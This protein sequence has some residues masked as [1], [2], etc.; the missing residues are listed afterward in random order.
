MNIKIKSAGVT[1]LI[2]DDYDRVYTA[3]KNKLGGDDEQLFTERIPGHEYLQWELPGEGWTPLSEGDPLMVQEVRQEL[4]K[5]KQVISQRFGANQ[6]MAQRILSVPDDSYVYYKANAEGRLLIRLTAWG[7]RYPERIGGGGAEGERKPKGNT[8]FVCI[9]ILYDNKPLPNKEFFVNGFK[10]VTDGTG[11]Y[12][13]GDLPIGYK[14]ELKVGDKQQIVEVQ[15]GQSDIQVDTTLFASVEIRAM[16]DGNPYSEVTATLS[17]WGHE[18]KL[19][20]D[21]NGKAFAKVPQDPDNGMCTIS[22]GNDYQQLPL[23]QPLTVFSFNVVSPPKE[24]EHPEDDTPGDTTGDVGKEEQNPGDPEIKE[25]KGDGGNQDT[26]QTNDDNHEVEAVDD[27]RDEEE[28]KSSG[29]DETPADGTTQPQEE[30]QHSTPVILEVLAA[31]SLLGLVGFTYL[32]C[33]GLLFG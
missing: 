7:Y 14:F 28:K 8:Q 25:D 33:C 6:E 20:T 12:N 11:V 32:Y 4:L 31:L 18:L 21:T 9:H 5:R 22:I 26:S 15:P 23:V 27:K 19:T 13:V 24:E 16:L 2:G 1:C 10:R 29:Q 17:Y 30:E 3:L